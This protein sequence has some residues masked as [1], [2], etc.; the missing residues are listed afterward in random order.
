[1]LAQIPLQ[2]VSDPVHS[3]LSQQLAIGM[4]PPLQGLKPV[5]Q[6][7]QRPAPEQL[8]PVGQET[9]AGAMQEPAAQVPTPT[10]L[11]FTQVALPQVPFG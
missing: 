11:P 9:G 4:Q 8:K 5:A 7:E 2:A 10:R 1:L 6:L 3:V